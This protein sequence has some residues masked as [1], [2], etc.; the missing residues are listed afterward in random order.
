MRIDRF[1]GHSVLIDGLGPSS[2]IVDL[3]S[4]HGNFAFA[5]ANRFQCKPFCVEPNPRLYQAL[6]SNPNV[7]AINLAVATRTGWVRFFLAENTECSS[8][9]P[10][11]IS[12]TI[13][14][15]NCHAVTL[16]TLL[17]TIPIEQVDVLKV[18]IEGLELDLLASLDARVL[19]RINQLTVEFHESIGMGTT[20]QVLDAIAHLKGYGFGILRGSF[21]DYSDVLFLHEERLKMPSNWRWMA[22]AEKI[23]NGIYRRLGVSAR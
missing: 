13:G 11:T 15:I 5:V 9:I 7:S 23:R 20:K 21:F 16:E 6:A 22:R 10:P 1:Y 18:D 19:D 12:K 4:N 14:E 17:K 2:T 3:G 8:L